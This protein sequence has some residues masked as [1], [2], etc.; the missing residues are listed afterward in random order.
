VRLTTE[1][2]GLHGFQPF[3]DAPAP[4]AV[5]YPPVMHSVPANV[6]DGAVDTATGPGRGFRR[7][8]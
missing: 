6:A 4:T 3:A 7:W 1:C 5:Q 8:R 2:A